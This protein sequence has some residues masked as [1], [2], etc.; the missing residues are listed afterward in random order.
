MFCLFGLFF[1][2]YETPINEPLIWVRERKGKF[3]TQAKELIYPPSW[4]LYHEA[5]ESA[6]APPGMLVDRISPPPL[7]PPTC[8]LYMK[9]LILLLYLQLK[10][11]ANGEGAW[12][13]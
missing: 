5:I 8:L 12:E 13:P 10:L 6:A 3:L 1:A 9:W 11:L 2:L 4:C 7:P